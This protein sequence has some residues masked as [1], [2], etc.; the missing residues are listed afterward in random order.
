VDRKLVALEQVERA[1][2]ELARLAAVGER[3]SLGPIL[4]EWGVTRSTR[5][6]AGPSRSTVRAGRDLAEGVGQERNAPRASFTPVFVVLP[7]AT[8]P[9]AASHRSTGLPLQPPGRTA[10]SPPLPPAFLGRFMV[11]VPYY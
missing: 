3:R 5:I 11:A 2:A 10:A 9:A 4:I 1:H 8:H 7:P 6:P